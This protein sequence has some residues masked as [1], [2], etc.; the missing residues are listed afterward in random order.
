[1]YA[2]YARV[3]TED[4][5]RHGYSLDS[6]IK[7]CRERLKGMA[8]ASIREYVDDGYSGEY[9]E[10][11]AL[12]RL[13]EDL[14]TGTIKAVL[15]YD[16]DRM[17]RNLTVQLILADEIE[18]AGAKLFFITGDYDASPEGRLF[19]SMKGAVSAYEKAKIRE[20]TVRG[21]R[22]KA[23]Q[24][25]IVFN[26][27]PYG[28]GWDE[29]N[30]LYVV[31][32]AQAEVVRLIYDLFL[33][34]NLGTRLIALELK[35][36]GI[37]G[38]K[39]KPLS[40]VTVHKVLSREMYCGTHYLFRQ[41]VQKTGQNQRKITNIPPEEW[42]PVR[43]PAI[44][45]R[46]RWEKAQIR[47]KGNQKL[48]KRNCQHDYL[49]RGVLYCSL[50]GR[51]MIATT[52]PQPRKTTAPK[53]YSY[54]TCITKESGIYALSGNRCPCMRIPV[55]SFDE[56]IWSIFRSVAEGEETFSRFLKPVETHD[57]SA[58][59][60][61]LTSY[62][63]ELMKRQSQIARLIREGLLDA[64]A[65][66]DEL[67]QAKQ[68]IASV[69][70]RVLLLRTSQ[71]NVTGLMNEVNLAEI[72]EAITFEQRREIIMRSGYR[73][74]VSRLSPDQIDYYFE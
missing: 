28:Y 23:A 16:P 22:Q 11:P 56:K 57:N 51:G 67:R 63:D 66:E 20:R 27:K 55:K 49:L 70:A 44:I 9:I 21:K 14:R 2:I 65:A 40:P 29:A 4:Q 15:F 42:L 43:V 31:D 5:A 1:M 7:S 8:V 37:I 69:N 10:R 19:F 46:E 30:S 36:L 53:D 50:C 52:R 32:E 13:R 48:A 61:R 54:Y 39:K 35:Q 25:K 33:E 24:G 3:S 17:S 47:L 45:S 64:Y 72:M 73:I 74:Y 6:Q 59:I 18:K 34:H 62:R 26:A 68:D 38:P 71:E 41:R 58:E 60:A 12:D